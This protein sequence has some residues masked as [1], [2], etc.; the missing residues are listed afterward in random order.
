MPNAA[1][2]ELI[3]IFNA[4][5]AAANPAAAVRR[6]A[7]LDGDDLCVAGRRYALGD[8][9]NV[10]IVGM[11]KAAGV[12]AT[13]LE[14][15]L[16]ERVSGGWVNVKS[17]HGADLRRATPHEAGHPLPDERGAEGAERIGEL[18]D[19]A[20]EDD[21]VLCVISGGGSA[22]LP[23]PVEGVSLDDKQDITEALLR[24]GADIR[25]INTVRKHLSR[26]KGGQLSQRAMPARVVTLIL[27]DVIGDPLDV[28]ASGPTSPDP[29]TY[30]DALAILDKYK[31]RSACPP[32]VA[33]H[34]D[35]GAA[36]DAAETPKPGDPLFERTQNVIV[37]S[38]ASALDAAADKAR[39]LGYNVMTLT[40][41]L[42]GEAREAAR[43]YAAV[44]RE[45]L[46]A[47]RPVP[48][49]ACVLSGGET[50]VT[51]RGDGRGGRNQEFA[52]A[53]AIA[54]RGLR[55]AAVLAAG[56]DGTDG[57]TDAA[58]AFADDT[59]C[60]RADTKGMNAAE[61]LA[62]NDSYTFFD[63]LGDLFKTGPTGT[64]VMDLYLLR[65]GQPDETD[66]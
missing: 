50:T 24:C 10:F 59:T 4:G 1:K 7:H 17:L 52:L 20:G 38:N 14:K 56:T 65:V 62:R 30:A 41:T 45:A 57:P 61:F 13:A 11:G 34:L 63:R 5:V 8:A 21:L 36:G 16:G 32:A 51:L 12:M 19:G 6:S 26:L 2:Q 23:A 37:G 25:E 43:V 46:S 29:T 66:E 40:T 18:L 31:L 42:D 47:G 22:L 48:P 44:A 35:A 15:M 54:M 3:A 9:R 28:I 39:Q 58:G 64:N 60:A 55:G 33:R 53:A 27:S 49:P